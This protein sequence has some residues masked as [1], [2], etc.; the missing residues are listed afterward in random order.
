M[1]CPKCGH[2]NPPTAAF[3]VFCGASLASASTPGG[4]SPSTPVYPP[5]LHPGHSGAP[6]PAAYPTMAPAY[7]A[8]AYTP[9]P[10]LPAF[11]I[12][13]PSPW[14]ERYAIAHGLIQTGNILR[15]L[16]IVLGGGLSFLL[17]IP[18]AQL[19]S[20]VDRFN[21]AGGIILWLVL[22]ILIWGGVVGVGLYALGTLVRASGFQMAAM[23]N[24]EVQ[25]APEASLPPE[26]RERILKAAARIGH[27]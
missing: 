12:D 13:L 16:G 2:E 7:T 8:P 1:V 15:I 4:P 5:S 18:I 10:T 20:G 9:A 3:C 25:T 22:S 11:L 14:R 6:S 27:S 26:Q 21:G 17:L 24:I 19:A 23:L